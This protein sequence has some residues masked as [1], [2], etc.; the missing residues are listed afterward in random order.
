[1]RRRFEETDMHYSA[2]R[3]Q[4]WLDDV[5][6]PASADRSP[7]PQPFHFTGSGSEYFRI[8][9]VNLLLTIVTVGIYS[10][11]AKVRTTRY[12]Y[13]HTRV[14]DASFDYHGLPLAILKGRI[15]ALL[16]LAAYQFALTISGALGVAILVALAAAGPWLIWKSLKFKLANSSYRGIRFA[17]DGSA[18]QVYA[19][20]LLLPVLTVLTLYLLAPF[21]HQRM[22]RFQHSE[23]RFGMTRFE[24][25]GKASA[26]YK[27][28]GVGLLIGVGGLVIIGVLFGGTLAALITAKA[29]GFALGTLMLAL[30]SLYLLAFTLFPILMTMIQNL[31][32]SST[33]LGPHR[34]ASNMR[35]TRAAWISI[36]NLLG[37]VVTLGLFLPFAKVRM[38]RYRLECLTLITN[39]SVEDF[40]AT[41]QSSQSATGEGV[42]DLFGM[43]ISL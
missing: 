31:V 19:I 39:G 10:A 8:W 40:I 5:E 2:A 6:S 20:F 22:K 42:A 24:F 18:R 9:I 3:Q 14:A 11:W 13:Q 26:F 7:M 30:L 12:F 41:E 37:I 23:S 27:V 16:L 4:A 1:M 43:D 25:D 36:T 17:F 21:T 35:W 32:W 38:L 29:G 33:A 15:V 28:Y 34:F